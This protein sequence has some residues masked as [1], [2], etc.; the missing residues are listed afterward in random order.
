ML[1]QGRRA[2]LRAGARR[3]GAVLPE[4]RRQRDVPVAGQRR[5][6][7]RRSGMLFI[8]FTEPNRVRVSGR[9]TISDDAEL[10]ASYPGAQLVVHVAVDEV[11]PNC[12]RYIHRM[13]LRGAVAVRPG[14]RRLGAGAGL[15]ARAVGVRRAGRRRSGP[16]LSSP[17]ER[18]SPSARRSS[19]APAQAT[20]THPTPSPS[21]P[22]RTHRPADPHRRPARRRR[23]R[24][25]RRR[26]APALGAAAPADPFTLGVSAGDPDARSAVLWTRLTGDGAAGRGR[27]GVGARR[28]RGVHHRHRRAARRRPRRPTATAC[29]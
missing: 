11:F 22:R 2:G 15:E 12:P 1:V 8:D 6:R 21:S 7:T 3:H 18:C 9:A 13:A 28:R 24:R 23:R 17:G 25:P 27:R 4:L 26:P 16:C 29:T 10:L 14:G 20:A 5:S 19:S